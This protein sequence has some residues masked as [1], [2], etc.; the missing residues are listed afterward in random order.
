MVDPVGTSTSIDVNGVN[1][2]V[3]PTSI[4]YTIG[5]TVTVVPQLDPLWGF[6]YWQTDSVIMI[7]VN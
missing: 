1:I 4:N 2:N 5:D 3:F 6:S 7:I